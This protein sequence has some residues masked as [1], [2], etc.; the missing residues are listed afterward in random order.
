MYADD[1]NLF[2]GLTLLTMLIS[3]PALTNASTTGGWLFEA[4]K[5]RGVELFYKLHYTLLY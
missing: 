4:A 1:T 5:C 2:T 3:A